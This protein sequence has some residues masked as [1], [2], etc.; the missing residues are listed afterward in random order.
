VIQAIRAASFSGKIFSR[1]S[2]QLAEI[3]PDFRARFVIRFQHPPDAAAAHA[4]DAVTL[5]VAAIRKSGPNRARLRDAIQAL[6]PYQGVSGKIEWDALGR[7]TRP[8]RLATR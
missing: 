1:A 5:V 8:V 7:N 4:Y 6:S 2:L 3:S